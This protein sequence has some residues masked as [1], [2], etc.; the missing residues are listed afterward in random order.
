LDGSETPEALRGM[1]EVDALRRV[2]ARHF[3]R[4]G[5]EKDDQ[6]GKNGTAGKVRGDEKDG[7]GAP[8]TRL[9]SLRAR[10]PGDRLESPYD[11][12]LMALIV[13]IGYCGRL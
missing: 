7:G 1:P 4:G 13:G 2:W 6:A 5:S 10:G 9:K 8:G 12:A 3:A 11:I